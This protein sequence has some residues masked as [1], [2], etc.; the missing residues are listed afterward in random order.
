MA[1]R[2]MDMLKMKLQ[3]LPMKLAVP[4][5]HSL[6]LPALP[7]KMKVRMIK[8]LKPMPR[9]KTAETWKSH[10]KFSKTLAQ[11]SNDKAQAD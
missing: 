3:L 9:K 4:L 1:R 2:Q 10:G 5:N 11:S 7:T 6:G 8:M